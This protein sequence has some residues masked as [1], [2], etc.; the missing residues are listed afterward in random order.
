MAVKHQS[1]A[2]ASMPREVATSL[3]SVSIPVTSEL[4]ETLG[5]PARAG[6]HQ[7][8]LAFALQKQGA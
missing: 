4:P 1:H 3:C 8:D 5:T 2:V 7:I 6:V